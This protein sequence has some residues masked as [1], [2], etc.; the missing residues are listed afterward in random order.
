MTMK[1]RRQLSASQRRRQLSRQQSKVNSR[2]QA[3]FIHEVYQAKSAE[4]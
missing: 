4:Q 2:R 1:I 3:H